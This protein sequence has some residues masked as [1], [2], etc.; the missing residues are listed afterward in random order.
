MK[1]NKILYN[2][3]EYNTYGEAFEEYLIDINSDDTEFENKDEAFK[4]FIDNEIDEESKR[5][6]Y[7]LLDNRISDNNDYPYGEEDDEQV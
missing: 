6:Y 1:T 3:V 2:G 5:E 7:E 4:Y